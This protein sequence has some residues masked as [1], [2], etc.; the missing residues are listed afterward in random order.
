MVNPTADTQLSDPLCTLA[1]HV[2]KLATPIGRGDEEREE[3]KGKGG[4]KAYTLRS[5][6]TSLSVS[7][8]QGL[9]QQP[10]FRMK[11]RASRSMRR[12]T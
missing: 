12:N 11:L 9:L 6:L 1:L 7:T 8:A 3:G 4:E 2:I 5:H 10:V